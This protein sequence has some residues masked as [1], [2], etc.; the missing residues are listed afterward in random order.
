MDV[1]LEKEKIDIDIKE[2]QPVVTQPKEI[3]PKN[4]RRKAVE[5]VYS[6]EEGF[7]VTKTEYIL[8]SASEDEESEVKEEKPKVE[9]KPV[10]TDKKSPPK[11]TA[12]GKKG[13]S[14]ATNQPT[15]MNFFKKK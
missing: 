1:D 11:A 8:V 15:L 7:V 6:D 5:K 4:K 13:K 14:V 3:I 12:K 2:E 9:A 10:Q